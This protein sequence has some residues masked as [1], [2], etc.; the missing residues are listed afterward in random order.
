MSRSEAAGRR[1]GHSK[2]QSPNQVVFEKF[3][4]LTSALLFDRRYY[5]HTAAL[6]LVGQLA[7]GVL[8]IR[9]VKCRLFLRS[10]QMLKTRHRHR[11]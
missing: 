11:D 2:I 8:L 1:Q 4:S 3:A 10:E 9:Y 7:L 6:V 5:W